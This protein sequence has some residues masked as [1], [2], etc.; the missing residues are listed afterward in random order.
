M[1]YGHLGT[2][3]KVIASG[4]PIVYSTGGIVEIRICN[5]CCASI[6]SNG[7]MIVTDGWRSAA[8]RKSSTYA[9]IFGAS[10]DYMAARAAGCVERSAG[11]NLKTSYSTG[12]FNDC[13]TAQVDGPVNH[14]SEVS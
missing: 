5:V 12:A 1:R 11:I 3:A 6:Q 9:V 10:K 7:I 13:T 4:I 8:C 14:R 2:I